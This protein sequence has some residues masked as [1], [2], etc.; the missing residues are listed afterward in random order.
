MHISFEA[1]D[2]SY[3][4]AIDGEIIQIVFDESEDD[5]E[6]MEITKP[7]FLV[8]INYEFPPVVPHTEW[9]N[10]SECDGGAKIISYKLRE[11]SFQVNLDNN[12]SFDIAFNTDETT[13]NNI[14]N[15]LARTYGKE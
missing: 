6:S 4:E 15:F 2:V 11:N 9:F 3:N 14:N 1:K 8:S 10:G 7:Y 5:N 12:M 13:F